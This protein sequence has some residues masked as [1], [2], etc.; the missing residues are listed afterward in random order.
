MPNIAFKF[1]K[2]LCMHILG[3][4]MDIIESKIKMFVH[5]SRISFSYLFASELSDKY[6]EMSYPMDISITNICIRE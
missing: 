6:F 3:I 4:D 5:P 1:L 2:T